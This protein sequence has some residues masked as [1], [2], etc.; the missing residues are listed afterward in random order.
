MEVVRDDAYAAFVKEKLWELQKAKRR[1]VTEEFHVSEL[2]SPRKAYWDRTEGEKPTDQSI[3][4]FIT[5]EAFH[6]VIQEAVGVEI[7]EQ[8]LY[9]ELKKLKRK[10][11]GTSDILGLWLAEIKTSRKWTIPAFPDPEYVKQTG[12]YM[13]MSGRDEAYIV[14]V[15]FVAGRA[16]NGKSPS[17]LEIVSWK[18]TSTEQERTEILETLEYGAIELDRALEEKDPLYVMLCAQWKCGQV[19][20]KKIS[21]LCPHYDACKPEG[22]YPQEVLLTL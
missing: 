17:S 1:E 2:L 20:Q 10:I 15:F 22:R 8:K 14:V 3:G 11:T 19:Y 7:S 6:R 9:L 21:N 18:L 4:F 5:G 16:W 13:A 12:C